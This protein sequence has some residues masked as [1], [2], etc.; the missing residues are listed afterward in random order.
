MLPVLLCRY[1]VV[2]LLCFIVVHCLCGLLCFQLLFVCV[3]RG[4]VSNDNMCPSC[5]CFGC[6]TV[7]T[8]LPPSSTVLFHTPGCCLCHVDLFLYPESSSTSKCFCARLLGCLAEDFSHHY[9]Q[10]VSP[11]LSSSHG[12]CHDCCNEC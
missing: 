1:C 2:T 12:G 10:S 6:V 8:S 4:S 7:I 5:V 3:C 9:C 11:G